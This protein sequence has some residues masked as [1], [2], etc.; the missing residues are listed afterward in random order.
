VI[1]H[2]SSWYSEMHHNSFV[3]GIMWINFH[4]LLKSHQKAPAMWQYITLLLHIYLL[5]SIIVSVWHF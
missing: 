4:S 5:W 1:T 2:N 3:V